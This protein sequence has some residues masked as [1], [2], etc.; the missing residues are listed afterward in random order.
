MK[1]TIIGIAGGTASGKTTLSQKVCE[2]SKEYGTVTVI[3]LDDYYK[4]QD[5]LTFEER[6][7]INYDHP[8]SYDSDLIVKHIKELKKGNSIEKPIYDFTI[9]NRSYETVVVEP[10][11][12]IIVEG[13][14]VFAIPE[15]M[16]L[17]DIKIFVDTA[18]DIRFIRRLK[19][20]TR[21]RGRTIDSVVEQYLTTVR[22]MH[23]AFVEPSKKY[24]DII[25]PEGGKNDIAIDFITTKIVN[26]F[27][28]AK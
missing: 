2:A 9:H 10:A 6:V 24:A 11:D 14:M 7:K 18:D 16:K 4:R 1:T 17:F 19:R 12:V 20:D 27:N 28:K 23:L 26:L 8:S 5:N 22:P 25:I 13:I 3:R 15:L 21:D